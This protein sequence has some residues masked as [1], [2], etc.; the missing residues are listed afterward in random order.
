MKTSKT[1]TLYSLLVLCSVVLLG[2][3][4]KADENKPVSEIKAEADTM[5]IEKLRSMAIKYQ[6]AVAAKKVEVEKLANKLKAI[7]IAEK[8]GNEA[9][10]ITAELEAL[11]SSISA[12]KERFH[13]YYQKVKE[14][15]GDLSGL[16]V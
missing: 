15:G 4:K 10:T 8:F 13:V 2:C 6:D 1:I 11:N 3:G 14:Q 7:P 12:L 16:E 5:S 9:K